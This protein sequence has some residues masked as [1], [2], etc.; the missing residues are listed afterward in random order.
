MN[1]RIVR[2][3][4][5]FEGNAQYVNVVQIYTHSGRWED[6]LILSEMISKVVDDNILSVNWETENDETDYEKAL[7]YIY[8]N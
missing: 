3:D 2:R 8:G 5:S 4:V 6:L 1:A 7:N